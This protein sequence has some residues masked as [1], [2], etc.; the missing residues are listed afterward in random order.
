M[1][2]TRKKRMRNKITTMINNN[3]IYSTKRKKIGEKKT[4]KNYY[5]NHNI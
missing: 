4:E 2:N 3:Q 5:T 1:I